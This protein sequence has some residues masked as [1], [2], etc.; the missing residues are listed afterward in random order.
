MTDPG[1]PKNI[2]YEMNISEKKLPGE[3]TLILSLTQWSLDAL[4]SRF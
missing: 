2:R 4:M 3:S 1:T